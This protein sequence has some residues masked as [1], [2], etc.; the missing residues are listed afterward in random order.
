MLYKS[1]TMKLSPKYN[2]WQKQEAQTN[3]QIFE[4]K[5][6]HHYH[7]HVRVTSR[8]SNVLVEDGSWGNKIGQKPSL[9]VLYLSTLLLKSYACI[10]F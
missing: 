8:K 10:A 6:R 5:I 9:F 1:A 4:E 2:D 3:I 7:H